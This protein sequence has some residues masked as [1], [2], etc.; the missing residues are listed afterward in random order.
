MPLEALVN[1]LE[2]YT[3]LT[4]REKQIMHHANE[5]LRNKEIAERLFISPG[6]AKKHL[7]NIFQKLDAKN[8]IQAI[9]KWN[10]RA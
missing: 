8:K 2:K 9:N 4:E 6:T 7:K 10:K 1:G 3:V 5:G